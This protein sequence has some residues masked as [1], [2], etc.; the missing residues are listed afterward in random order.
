MGRLQFLKLSMILNNESQFLFTAKM[1]M[2]TCARVNLMS[3]EIYN[4]IH[5]KLIVFCLIKKKKNGG[6]KN[7]ES[8]AERSIDITL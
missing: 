1:E 7:S 3:L 4:R 6:R 5:T 2:G 8:S